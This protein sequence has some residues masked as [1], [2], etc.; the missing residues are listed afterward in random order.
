M[1]K[2]FNFRRSPT[3]PNKAWHFRLDEAGKLHFVGDR[4]GVDADVGVFFTNHVTDAMLEVDILNLRP[5]LNKLDQ[6]VWRKHIVYIN[7]PN[8]IVEDCQNGCREDT[9]V[10]NL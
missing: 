4:G 5:E 3:F 2:G 8:P 7:L 1:N 9:S 10:S 6:L